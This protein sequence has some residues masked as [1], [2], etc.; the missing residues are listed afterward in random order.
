MQDIKGDSSRGINEK[1]FLY[2]RFSWQKGYGTFSYSKSRI[3]GVIR[4]IE[5]QE[6]HHRQKSFIDE[7]REFL[8]H[9]EIEY[10]ERYIFKPLED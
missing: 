2:K 1:E 5:N 4:Y 10:D 8:K 3:S 6:T 7:Y 9:F